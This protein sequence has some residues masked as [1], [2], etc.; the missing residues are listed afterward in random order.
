MARKKGIKRAELLKLRA[1]R[2]PSQA[3]AKRLGVAV[4]TVSY[5][6]YRGR[7]S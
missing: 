6:L 4:S 5:H 7:G 1:K 2:H 3:I